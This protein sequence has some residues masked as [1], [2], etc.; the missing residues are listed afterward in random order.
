M[1][2]NR[3]EPVVARELSGAPG[4]GLFTQ[5]VAM[6]RRHI[7]PDTALEKTI[8]KLWREHGEAL[9]LLIEHR[10][11]AEKL[12][13]DALKERADKLT[14][15]LK[16][17]P[18]RLEYDPNNSTARLLRF[19]VPGWDDH[20]QMGLGDTGWTSSGRMV[21]VELGIHKKRVWTQLIIGPAAPGNEAATTARNQLYRAFL[22][23]SQG[24]IPIGRRTEK[25]P[26]K[27]KSIAASPLLTKAMFEGMERDG[28][29]PDAFIRKIVVAFVKNWE[30]RLPAIHAAMQRAWEAA[31]GDEPA[32]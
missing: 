26:P 27:W 8:R 17:P 12:V 25:L 24:D 31:R 4:A 23:P 2:V 20:A 30:N 18:L 1:V 28:E 11:D 14:V 15:V 13:L 22:N 21:M 10:P 3:L 19:F 9:E 5:Y 7:M 6:L 29:D 16:H 32:D